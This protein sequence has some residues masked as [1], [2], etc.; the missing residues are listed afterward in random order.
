MILVTGKVVMEADALTKIKPA[1]AK[2]VAASRAE[3]GCNEYRYGVCT[4]EPNTFLVLESWES[5]DALEKN[6]AT[7]H[8][9]EWRDALFKAGVVSRE[10][11]AVETSQA[12]SI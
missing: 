10:L 8:M 12:R 7:L 5:F 4:T 11:V 2:M 3:A 6:F 1:M 9:H